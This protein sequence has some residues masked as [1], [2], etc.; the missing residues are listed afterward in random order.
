MGDGGWGIDG[1]GNVNTG[2]DSIR[3]GLVWSGW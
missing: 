3:S 2:F 1:K